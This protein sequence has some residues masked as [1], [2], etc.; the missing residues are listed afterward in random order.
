MKEISYERIYKSQEYLSPLG[1]IHH[2]ALFGGY[3]LSVGDAVFAMVSEGE[4]YLR[5]CEQSATYCVKH[6][7]SFLTL[8]K[9][10]R[11]VLLNYFRVDEGLWQDRERLLQLSSLS[12]ESARRERNKR[13]Q[14]NRL[15]DLPNLTF[16]IE[17][18]LYEAGIT[19]ETALR[20]L[21]AEACWLKIRTKNR[22]LGIKVLFALEGAI[23]G[24]HEAALPA[25][26]RRELTEWF[27]ALPASKERHS[28][29]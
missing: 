2:R 22:H 25:H 13:H 3:T 20:A 4:L 19:D 17:V 7:S 26:R 6:A 29:R 15:K 12:L 27:N 21:G 10:G 24:L 1:E 16:Q 5:A 11:P 9:R 28:G 23:E 14:R 8:V 18:L